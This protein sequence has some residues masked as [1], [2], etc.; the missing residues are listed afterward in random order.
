MSHIAFIALGSNLDDPQRHIRQGFIDLG[1][2]PQTH[3]SGQSR[4]YRSAPVG[5]AHQPDF[6]NAVA[7]IDTGLA[8]EALLDALLAIEARHGRQREFPNSP[9]TLDLDILLYDDC[10]LHSARLT[11]PHPRMGGRD[12]VLRPLHELA[13]DLLVPGL[14]PLSSLLNQCQSQ[15]AFPLEASVS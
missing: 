6:I 1:A 11:I 8:P 2:L 5:Y 9:R 14:G 12:F 7:R 4:L 3:L 13:P 15:Q 10:L